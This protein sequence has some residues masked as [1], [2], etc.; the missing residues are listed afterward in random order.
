MIF[1]KRI[2]K[3]R[4]YE[5]LRGSAI[6]HLCFLFT[7][8]IRCYALR[9]PS[10]AHFLP[11]F[12]GRFLFLVGRRLRQAFVF[13][14]WKGVVSY[15]ARVMGAREGR[16]AESEREEGSVPQLIIPW[17]AFSI[18]HLLSSLSSLLL[19]PSG[20]I[21]MRKRDGFTLC[22]FQHSIIPLWLYL[23]NLIVD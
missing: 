22:A 8:S 9:M 20:C 12:P 23:P 6:S 19:F 18:S 17:S 10:S 15:V 11:P 7:S 4:E 2:W 14:L 3:M 5:I 21:H 1:S 13:H 16:G